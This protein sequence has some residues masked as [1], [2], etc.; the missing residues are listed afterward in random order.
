MNNT[1]ILLVKSR[2][3][4]NVLGEY[5]VTALSNIYHAAGQSTVMI[6]LQVYNFVHKKL[7][8]GWHKIMN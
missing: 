8:P 7:T 2:Y 6:L 3:L 4:N 1:F 5:Y